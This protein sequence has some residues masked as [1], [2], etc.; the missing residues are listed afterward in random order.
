MRSIVLAP[1]DPVAPSSVTLRST[2]A[3]A[4]RTDCD[5]GICDLIAPPVQ[6]LGRNHPSE[7]LPHQ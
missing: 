1:I 2:L 3:E 7:S 6:E 5:F 4:E